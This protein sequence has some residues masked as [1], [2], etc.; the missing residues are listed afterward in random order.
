M[1]HGGNLKLNV[2]IKLNLTVKVKSGQI[3]LTPPH[4]PHPKAK[5][6]YPHMRLAVLVLR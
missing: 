1:M 2:Y 6:E 5:M 4:P 3:K